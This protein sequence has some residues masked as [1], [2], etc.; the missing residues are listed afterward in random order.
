MNT[1]KAIARLGPMRVANF[2]ADVA[3]VV[4]AA[5]IEGEQLDRLLEEDGVGELA[6]RR[7]PGR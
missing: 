1:G 5:E 4:G 7:A 2:V 6:A 3:P